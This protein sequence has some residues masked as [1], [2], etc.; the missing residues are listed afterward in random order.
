MRQVL[1]VE[2][3]Q[4]VAEVQEGQTLPADTEHDSSVIRT[5]NIEDII[6]LLCVRTQLRPASQMRLVKL[7][8][9]A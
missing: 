3:Q 2:E 6:G 7:L 8:N 4:V 1:E 5:W 9:S